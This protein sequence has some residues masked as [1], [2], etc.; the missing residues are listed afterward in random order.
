LL[1]VNV[2]Y[3]HDRNSD[4]II[5]IESVGNRHRA[6]CSPAGTPITGVHLIQVINAAHPDHE[7]VGFWSHGPSPNSEYDNLYVLHA[8]TNDPTTSLGATELL[9]GFYD[10]EMIYCYDQGYYVRSRNISAENN[11]GPST[12][13]WAIWRCEQIGEATPPSDK[14]LGP[15]QNITI[16]TGTMEAKLKIGELIMKKCSVTPKMANV[17][18][19]VHIKWLEWYQDMGEITKLVKEGGGGFWNYHVQHKSEYNFPATSWIFVYPKGFESVGPNLALPGFRDI[20]IEYDLPLDIGSPKALPITVERR[21]HKKGR[22]T[23]FWPEIYGTA[24]ENSGLFVPG[25]YVSLGEGNQPRRYPK[26]PPAPPN[27]FYHSEQVP[28]FRVKMENAAHF[29]NLPVD[30]YWVRNEK[31]SDDQTQPGENVLIYNG[32]PVR[33]ANEADNVLSTRGNIYLSK[34]GNDV[35]A[36]W[37]RYRWA[38]GWWFLQVVWGKLNGAEIK[39][40]GEDRYYENYQSRPPREIT[41]F[42]V[43]NGK[44]YFGIKRVEPRWKNTALQI[45]W[46]APPQTE[47]KPANYD[48]GLVATALVPYNK[49]DYLEQGSVIRLRDKG[50]PV[51]DK[52][53]LISE[54]DTLMHEIATTEFSSKT[55]APEIYTRLVLFS[56]DQFNRGVAGAYKA[57]ARKELLD[58][59]ITIMEGYDI[60]GEICYADGN[61]LKVGHTATAQFGEALDGDFYDWQQQEWHGESISPDE[62]GGLAEAYLAE[63]RVIPGSVKVTMIADKRE[64]IVTDKSDILHEELPVPPLGEVYIKTHEGY[65]YTETCLYL[66]PAYL[67]GRQFIFAPEVELTLYMRG[68]PFDVE[69]EYHTKRFYIEPFVLDGTLYF[70]ETETGA[71]YRRDT[72]TTWTRVTAWPAPVAKVDVFDKDVYALAESDFALMKYGREWPGYINAEVGGADPISVFTA[73]TK[74]AQAADCF[75]GEENGKIMLRPRAQ[76][77]SMVMNAEFENFE[78]CQYIEQKQ[79]RGVLITYDGGKAYVGQN[80]PPEDLILKRNAPYVFDYGLALELA[81]RYYAYFT[82]GAIIYDVETMRRELRVPMLAETVDVG[83]LSGRLIKY[84]LRGPKIGMLI[85]KSV[86]GRLAIGD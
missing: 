24:D 82:S 39:K 28:D 56:L 50:R 86:G 75:L 48:G 20:A 9:G 27:E 69:Y 43:F 85:E 23:Y 15:P 10:D 81:S 13:D 26:D 33:I 61:E 31:Q 30:K 70:N 53:Y 45:V 80:D 62:Y 44:Y 47:L 46:G 83:E 79:Y 34:D 78:T 25:P 41:S 7:Y 40:V 12:N 29:A 77:K 55:Y 71:I 16:L 72:D 65:E 76:G 49:T 18:D 5:K 21:R 11:G 59:Y 17:G 68:Q 22:T 42:K 67:G 3:P 60:R 84:E 51:G 35:Y 2:A 73:L 66:N 52:E 63:A 1:G 6:W 54:V 32:T 19:R 37:N 57:Q 74:I 58:K 4:Y 36:A 38:K 14:T 8:V 64:F